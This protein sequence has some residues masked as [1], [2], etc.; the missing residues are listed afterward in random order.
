MWH[1]VRRLLERCRGVRAHRAQRARVQLPELEREGRGVRVVWVG[2]HIRQ[3]FVQ[4]PQQW[5]E[6]LPPHRQ[7][8]LWASGVGLGTGR[9][10]SPQCVVRHSEREG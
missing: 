7:R 4:P 9:Q 5:Q 2:R 6:V 8:A 1:L 10:A 3:A